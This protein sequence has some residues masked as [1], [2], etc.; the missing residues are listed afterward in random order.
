MPVDPGR[1]TVEAVERLR[2]TLDLLRRLF[3]YRTC[4]RDMVWRKSSGSA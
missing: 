2:E 1:F 3:P 4:D